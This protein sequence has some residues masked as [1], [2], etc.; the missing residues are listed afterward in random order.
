VLNVAEKK[1]AAK[2]ISE[3]L[4]NGNLKLKKKKLIFCT[5]LALISRFDQVNAVPEMDIPNSARF[6]SSTTSSLSE[7]STWL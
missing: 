1:D 5:I 4:S 6:M 7:M 2:T 3:L